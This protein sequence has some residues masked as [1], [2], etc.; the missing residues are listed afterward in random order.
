[1]VGIQNNTVS[2]GQKN[3]VRW[4]NVTWSR[5]TRMTIA[6]TVNTFPCWYHDQVVEATVKYDKFYF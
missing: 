1:M 5:N 6:A 4:K 2:G 3:T